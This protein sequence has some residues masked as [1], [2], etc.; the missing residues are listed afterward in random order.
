MGDPKGA[1]GLKETWRGSEGD[2]E[3]EEEEAEG[4]EE[5]KRLRGEALVAL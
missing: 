5:D 4:E 1:K 3:E 2:E